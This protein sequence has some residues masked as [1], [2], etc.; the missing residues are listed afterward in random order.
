MQTLDGEMAGGINLLNLYQT[1]PLKK[2][3]KVLRSLVVTGV[4]Q[5]LIQCTK[6]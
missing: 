4:Q 3:N 6:H 5:V 2:E 1:A